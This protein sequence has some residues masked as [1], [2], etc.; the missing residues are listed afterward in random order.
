MKS[1]RF[2][3]WRRTGKTTSRH[4]SN[5]RT[6]R[7]GGRIDAGAQIPVALGPQTEALP[8]KGP[9]NTHRL[10]PA[11]EEREPEPFLEPGS[12]RPGDLSAVPPPSSVPGLARLR[13]L[14]EQRAFLARVAV[15]G[16]AAALVLALLIPKRFESRTLLMP[17]EQSNLGLASL[18]AMTRSSDSLGALAGDLL[19]MKASGALFMGIL[20]SRTVEERIIERFQLRAVYRVPRMEQARKIL[21]TRTYMMEDRK[22]G[23]LAVT[24]TDG[25]ASRAAAMGKAYVEELDRL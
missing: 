20:S 16:A 23:I 24:V 7:V 17:P 14:W 10:A 22:S 12:V 2:H 11:D 5:W 13:L 25:D 4:R 6:G 9:M 1:G 3:C 15:W 8:R 19:G 21:E 18:M